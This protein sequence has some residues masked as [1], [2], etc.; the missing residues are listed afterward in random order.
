MDRVPQPM[1]DLL[2][3]DESKPLEEMLPTRPLSLPRTWGRST[4]RAQKFS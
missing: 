4:S 3:E 1:L 2:Y